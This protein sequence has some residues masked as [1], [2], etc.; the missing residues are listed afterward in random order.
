MMLP[1]FLT[2]PQDGT[3]EVNVTT[4]LEK[5]SATIEIKPMLFMFDQEKDFQKEQLIR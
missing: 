5:A 4:D 1:S 3:I 2:E